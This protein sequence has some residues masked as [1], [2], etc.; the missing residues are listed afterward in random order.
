TLDGEGV[1]HDGG[2]FG[3]EDSIH[4]TTV[5][6][7]SAESADAGDDGG[8]LGVGMALKTRR[9]RRAIIHG[10]LVSQQA[11]SGFPAQG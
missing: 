4:P 1:G 11:V 10:S 6:P 2:P 3:E 9:H 7:R 8:G 5:I